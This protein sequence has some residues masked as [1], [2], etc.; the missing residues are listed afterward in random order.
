MPT[1]QEYKEQRALK[2]AERQAKARRLGRWVPV[3]E[4]FCRKF[5]IDMKPIPSG[6]QFRVREYIVTW[7]LPTNKIVIQFRGS[8]DQRAFQGDLVPNEPKIITALKK[9]ARV[10]KEDASS[11]LK[12]PS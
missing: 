1:P 3:I 10:T 2:R 8:D 7:W 6:Y 5:G 11:V 12:I 4:V 9:L